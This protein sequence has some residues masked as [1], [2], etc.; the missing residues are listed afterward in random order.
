MKILWK[1]WWS[2]IH[3]L[4]IRLI[5]EK[6]KFVRT[7]PCVPCD[8]LTVCTVFFVQ[9]DTPA[10]VIGLLSIE[11][12]SGLKTY[13][14]SSKPD[15]VWKDPDSCESTG[16]DKYGIR[17]S[18]IALSLCYNNNHTRN[19]LCWPFFE[20]FWGYGWAAFLFGR[21]GGKCSLVPLFWTF[22]KYFCAWLRICKRCRL[23]GY[24]HSLINELNVKNLQ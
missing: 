5:L 7:K 9:G 10:L 1:I 18:G 24:L 13:P 17:E 2:S 20:A 19:E 12:E 14:D 3:R 6:S 16:A 11:G 8:T 4:E 15:D 22:R 23:C 21:G